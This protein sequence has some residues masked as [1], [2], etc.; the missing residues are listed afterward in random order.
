MRYILTNK[1]K[2]GK[3]VSLYS[4]ITI[5]FGSMRNAAKAE[6]SQRQSPFEAYEE[7]ALALLWSIRKKYS[8]SRDEE[9]EIESMIGANFRSLETPWTREK[10]RAFAKAYAS[11]HGKTLQQ[12]V[13]SAIREI[14][15]RMVP[16]AVATAG[17]VDHTKQAVSEHTSLPHQ[18]LGE[19]DLW[20][21]EGAFQNKKK[22]IA[23]L[24]EYIASVP[25]SA[26]LT[27]AWLKEFAEGYLKTK[28]YY[29]NAINLATIF[30]TL[31]DMKELLWN[32][33]RRTSSD[34]PSKRTLSAPVWN[35][36]SIQ[37][38]NLN[39]FLLVQELM[40]VYKNWAPSDAERD[41]FS[42]LLKDRAFTTFLGKN[43]LTAEMQFIVKNAQKV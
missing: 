20:C 27:L 34:A 26:G 1:V 4:L 40:Q 5:M 33:A 9:K 18:L 42:Q 8:L 19:V 37:K 3:V 2:Y 10:F 17:V 36:D 16:P 25:W 6:P 30:H 28:K 15:E 11:E 13:R 23:F 14:D 39:N 43:T 32:D 22:L 29:I 35:E 21:D 7:S 12:N 24:Q 38:R 41:F 31:D